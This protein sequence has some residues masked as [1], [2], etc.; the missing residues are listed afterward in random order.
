MHLYCIKCLIFTKTGNIKIKCEIDE[1]INLYSCCI[2]CGSKRL[3]AV[4]EEDLI[5]LLK[6]F[7]IYIKQC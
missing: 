7:K 6:R 1:E 3:G 2:N 5:C 4:N